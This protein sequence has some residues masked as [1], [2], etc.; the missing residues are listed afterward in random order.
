MINNNKLLK[1][2]KIIIAISIIYIIIM[3]LFFDKFMF[4]MIFLIGIIFFLL[5]SK[6]NSN[7]ANYLVKEKLELIIRHYI[8]LIIFWNILFHVL[9]DDFEFFGDSIDIFLHTA[10]LIIFLL[11]FTG[12]LK[13]IQNISKTASHKDIKL[14]RELPE[15]IKP[16]IIAY[17]MQE[18]VLDRSDI[19]ATL[20]DLVRRGYLKIQDDEHSFE[21]I[22][23]GILGKKLVIMKPINDLDD[24]EKHLVEWFS[25]TSKNNLEINISKLKELLKDSKTSK[26]DYEKWELLVKI[27]ANELN[28][29]DNQSSL[30]KFSNISEKISKKLV[31]VSLIT[32]SISIIVSLLEYIIPTTNSVITIFTIIFFIHFVTSI[33]AIIIYDL[34]LPTEYLN[35]YGN[36]KIKK[37]N[38]FI[39]FLKEFTI[40]EKRKVEE[41]Y[42]WEEYLVYGVAFGISKETI[43][44]MNQAYGINS[45]M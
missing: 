24:Y 33:L 9:F 20:L 43:N 7:S 22:A 10:I 17:L 15:Q 31:L 29:Y 1:I 30:S 38:G 44:T 12:I 32:L 25:K 28:F 42:L 14:Y 41:V 26:E 34:K 21:N 27:K 4:G 11:L 45:Y 5:T 3:K 37:W 13:S 23:N 16:A 8:L 35:K 19:S 2:E 40:I 39:K 36:E 18:K 6:R